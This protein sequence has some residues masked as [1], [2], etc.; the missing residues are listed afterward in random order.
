MVGG[1]Q[2]QWGVGVVLFGVLDVHFSLFGALWALAPFISCI[3]EGAATT[4]G[5][6][7][8]GGMIATVVT[9]S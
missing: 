7:E 1:G 4:G 2:A 6:G 8:M 3:T 5:V 9:L